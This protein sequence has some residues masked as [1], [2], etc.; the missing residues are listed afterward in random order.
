MHTHL[1]QEHREQNFRRLLYPVS[2]ALSGKMYS[3]RSIPE[4]VYGN[5]TNNA[6]KNIYIQNNVGQL[7]YH[8]RFYI[9]L[10]F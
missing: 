6:V 10:R 3:D 5:V 8:L 9:L 4:I 1:Q 7:R 2:F